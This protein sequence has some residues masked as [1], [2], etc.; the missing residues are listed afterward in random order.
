MSSEQVASILR[1]CSQKVRLVVARSVREPSI[2]ASDTPPFMSQRPSVTSETSALITNN[3]SGSLVTNVDHDG[4][5]NSS[6]NKLLLRTERLL[7]SNHNLEKIL[8]NLRE[9][10]GE[11]FLKVCECSFLTSTGEEN[12]SDRRCV[13]GT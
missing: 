4:I 5:I 9:Q 6:Q 1:Q 2:A 7:E 10:V 8:E 12:R 13:H 11:K 3:G